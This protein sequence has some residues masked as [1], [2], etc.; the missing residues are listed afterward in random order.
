MFPD[1]CENCGI[2]TKDLVEREKQKDGYTLNWFIC[3]YCEGR[4]YPHE[5]YPSRRW[6]ELCSACCGKPFEDDIHT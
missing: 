3:K 4:L 2:K 1:E 5:F 6:K